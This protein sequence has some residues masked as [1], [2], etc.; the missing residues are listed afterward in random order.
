MS[1]SLDAR[2]LLVLSLVLS[3]CVSVPQ[4]RFACTSAADCPS[5]WVC[6]ELRCR[7]PGDLPDA[8]VDAALADA[9]SVDASHDASRDAA[10]ADAT[11]AGSTDAGMPA[12]VRVAHFLP[13]AGELAVCFGAGGAWTLL[14]EDAIGYAAVGAS[15]TL[16]VPADT[17]TLAAYDPADLVAG[18][19]PTSTA[20]ALVT[21]TMTAG[22]LVPAG[23]YTVAIT[24]LAVGGSGEEE[25]E[26]VL[27]TDDPTPSAGSAR[28]RLFA[29]IPNPLGPVDLCFDRNP[30]DSLPGVPLATNVAFE[31]A[32]P[33]AASMPVVVGMLRVHTAG[34]PPCSTTILAETSIP[35]ATGTA[36][37]R[38][39]TF[40]DGTVG[41]VVVAGDAELVRP[42][43]C[44]LD[45]D[46]N[47]S[48]PTGT[49]CGPG[50][51]CTHAL[52][53]AIFALPDGP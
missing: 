3:G 20:S 41:T 10:T 38:V 52:A 28:V 14:T 46:C 37:G 31:D 44:T 47:A 48:G 13:G 7:T 39:A 35:L 21:A 9:G 19:C 40:P 6:S 15:V 32:S 27:L 12:K 26:L 2:P 23:T 49:F 8:A 43:S 53:P 33:Y 30:G 36:T 17:T 22:R 50:G 24:G 5:G 29:A 11:D 42:D 34:T 16:P 4:G 18:A 51:I 1:G 45:A 25:P